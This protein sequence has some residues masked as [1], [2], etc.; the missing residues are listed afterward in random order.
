VG[1][2]LCARVFEVYR[3]EATQV[4]FIDALTT[5]SGAEPPSLKGSDLQKLLSFHVNALGFVDLSTAGTHPDRKTIVTR[6]ERLAAAEKERARAAADARVDWN[7]PL[8]IDRAPSMTYSDANGCQLFFLFAP[9]E[10]RGEVVTF[11]ADASSLELT[12]QLRR[13]DLSKEQRALN[14]RIQVYERPVRPDLC[15]D[16]GVTMPAE[17]TWQAVSG[18]VEIELSP[19][20]TDPAADPRRQATVRILDAEFAGPGG[21]RVRL[22]HPIVLTAIVGF[23]GG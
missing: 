23:W 12:P 18:L 7:A 1:W 17:S 22:N 6:A 5:F 8:D 20:A 16:A 11:R 13:F 10:D 3:D 9:S 2:I 19:R 15:S 14:L 21:K 4:Q